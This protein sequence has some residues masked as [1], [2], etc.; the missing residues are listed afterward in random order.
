MVRLLSVCLALLLGLS[1]TA[2]SQTGQNIMSARAAGVAPWL[3]MNLTEVRD[4]HP[5]RPFIDVM[6]QSRDWLGHLPGQWGGWTE[7]DLRA[8]GALDEN[9]WPRFVPAE[10]EGIAA[11]ILVDLM[12]DAGGVA[13]TYRVTYEGEGE[14]SIEGRVGAVRRLGPREMWFTFTPGDGLVQVIIRRTDA[15]NP[16]RN[17]QVVHESHIAAFDRGE[18]FNPDWLARMDGM[19]VFR[20]MEWTNTN[21][22]KNRTWEDRP[23]LEHYTWTPN[24]VPLEVMIRLANETGVEPWFV[25]PHLVDDEYME[26]AATLI[27]DTLRPDLRAWIEY[28]NET[29]NWGFQQAHDIR[30]FAQERWGDGNL[31]QEWYA[32]R[33][34]QMVQ[35]FNRVF[36]GQEDR[37]VRV[38]ATQT[39]WLGLEEQLEAKRWQREDP[40]NPAPPTLFDVYAITGYFSALAGYPEK[41][42][43]VKRW[44]DD[45][46]RQAEAEGRAQGLGGIRLEEHIRTASHE[47]LT[48]KLIE[49]IRD[50]RHSGK[51][52]DSVKDYLARILPH[53]VRFA[54]K[55]GLDLVAYEGGSHLVGVGEHMWD[56]QLTDL[57]IH[58]NYTQGM[59]DLYTEILTGW[60]KAGGGTFVHFSDVRVPAV[61]GSF[62]ALRHLTDQ[63][64]RWDALVS[65]DP[66]KVR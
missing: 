34:A 41:A 47:A 58:V 40:A 35:I 5:Q 43:T 21:Y 12:P 3:G 14:L 50:G 25:M 56:Q 48:P 7:A 9:G 42:P 26:A 37:L 54:Q 44:L 65:F 17:I 63:N 2:Q 38:L 36:A 1:S 66:S 49:E 39:G 31:W 18:M 30:D 33:A 22:T 57:F 19:A 52:E 64:P 23:R 20:F 55:W 53:H 6:K 27:R 46:R 61:W 32:M 62:G 11:L 10:L 28:S 59:A 60:V 51:P 45:A 29:W 8:A 15:E 16:I 13:G 4:F 24:G